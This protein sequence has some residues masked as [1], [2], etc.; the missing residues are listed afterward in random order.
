M[1]KRSSEEKADLISAEEQKRCSL[2]LMICPSGEV[3]N[4]NPEIYSNMRVQ[5]EGTSES[6]SENISIDDEI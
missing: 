3:M 2:N 5:N 6:D 4:E 1:R